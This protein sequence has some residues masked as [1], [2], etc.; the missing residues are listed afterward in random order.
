[1]SH[2]IFIS[3]HFYF[4]KLT[5]HIPFLF[6]VLWLKDMYMKEVIASLAA[7]A[8]KLGGEVCLVLSYPSLSQFFLVSYTS[9]AKMPIL[10]KTL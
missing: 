9:L 1:M 8:M 5:L 4:I 2:L 3:F 10:Q 7:D 6:L